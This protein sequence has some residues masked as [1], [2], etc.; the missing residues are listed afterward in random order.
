MNIYSLLNKDAYDTLAPEYEARVKDLLPITEEAMNF[1]SQYTKPGGTI[2]D[3]GCG[4]GT[5]IQVLSQKGCTVTGIDI[6]PQMV[7][8]AKQ[9]NPK[10][11][12]I[13]GDFLSFPFTT[14][15]DGIVTFAFL[16]LFPQE[17]VV[18]IL[19]KIKLLLN[20]GGVALLTST[21]SK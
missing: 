7:R 9:R 17:N 13:M 14:T 1:F 12:V 15:F 5:V 18:S 4:V 20:P 10:A 11:T 2:L 21:E 8:F 6:A 16:H 19:Q 3:I